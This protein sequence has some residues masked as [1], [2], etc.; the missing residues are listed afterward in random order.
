[1]KTYTKI[2]ITVLPLALFFL[3]LSVGTIYYFSRSALTG[4][5]E[6]WLET[7]LTEALEIATEQVDLLHRYGYEG[8]PASVAKAKMDAGAAIASIQVGRLGYVFVVS[9]R[10]TIVLHPDSDLVG[11]DVSGETWFAEALRGEK[12][13]V[14]WSPDTRNLTLYAS[15]EPWDWLILVTDP[16]EEIFGVANQMK[17]YIVY[18]AVTATIVISLAL[19][20]LTRRLTTPLMWLTKGVDRIGKGHL[21]TRISISGRDEISYLAEG[22]NQMAAQLQDTLS[23]LRNR[24]AYFRSIIE[25]A[26]DI[27]SILDAE[28]RFRYVSPSVERV[29]GYRPDSLIGGDA[30]AIVHPEDRSRATSLFKQRIETSTAFKVTEYRMQHRDGSW[31]SVE[32]SAKNLLGHPAVAGVV[33]SSRDISMRKEALEALNRSHQELE[34][35][36]RERTAQLNAT[37][38]E[39]KEFAYAVSHDLKAPLRAISQLT[40]WMAEDYAGAFDQ[41]GRVMMDLILKRVKRMNDLID[42]VLSYSRIGR[43]R[44]NVRVLDLNELVGEVIE[45]M[46]TPDHIDIDV[47]GTLPVVSKDPVRMEQIFQNL[48]G[49]A[50]TYMDKP[51]GVVK[52]GCSDEGT[53]WRFSVSDNGP[54]IDRRYH[55][56]IFQIFQTLTP[57]DEHESSGIGLTLVKKSVEQYGGTVWVESENGIGSTFFFTLPKNEGGH[58]ATENHPFD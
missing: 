4:L 27:I 48:I 38:T 15:F 13:T 8:V 56:K 16:E 5:A 25:N 35:R 45:D 44:G 47:E 7:R 32:S 54:G 53:H 6:T 50:I 12:R 49:N 46:M 26:S 39:L 22:F 55:E 51:N 2:L 36:V 33:I 24:E 10:G 18:L 57:R 9:R 37:N 17:P 52:V 19:M 41:E 58:E 21:D 42:G 1:M 34:R 40:H 28:G 20:F 14:P 23:T 31:R 30:F 3:F 29:L 43:A 11:R